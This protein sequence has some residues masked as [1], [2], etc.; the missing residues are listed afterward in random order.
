MERNEHPLKSQ[1]RNVLQHEEAL[2]R[3]SES[4]KR[5]W[6]D[7]SQR[8]DSAD[9]TL[10]QVGKVDGMCEGVDTFIEELEKIAAGND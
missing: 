4:L 5:L 8:R 7:S 1:L 10:Y 3:V 9:D 6:R 2:R